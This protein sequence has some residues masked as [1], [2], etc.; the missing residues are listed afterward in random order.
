MLT[1]LA[2]C[3][4]TGFWAVPEPGTERML[5][6]ARVDA[7]EAP[8]LPPDGAV[9]AG[10]APPA[11]PPAVDRALLARGR[12]RFD[13]FCA[14]CHGVDGAAS[15]P[16]ARAMPLPPRDLRVAAIDAERVLAAIRDGYGLMPSY[17]DRVA[18]TDAYAV[19]AW[20]EVLQHAEVPLDALPAELRDE[21]LRALA[22]GSAP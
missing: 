15:T 4:L 10:E 20:V 21:A 5:V 3:A 16:V 9:P 19:A 22:P 6:Q 17:A 2:G 8:R 7:Y 1:L 13:V 12:D 14:P 11:A 18:G